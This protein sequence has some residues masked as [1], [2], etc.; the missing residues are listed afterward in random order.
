MIEIGNT[1]KKVLSICIVHAVISSQAFS[2]DVNLETVRVT[3]PSNATEACRTAAEELEKHLKYVQ[4]SGEFRG[5]EASDA[6]F[7]RAHPIQ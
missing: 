2:A 3:C 6:D 7:R 5:G 4:Q 1:M